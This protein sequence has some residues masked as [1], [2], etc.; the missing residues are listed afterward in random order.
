[1]DENEC[2]DEEIVSLNYNL[3]RKALFKFLENILDSTD[4]HLVGICKNKKHVCCIK[5]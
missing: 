1:M 3:V 2:N 5:K 4:H